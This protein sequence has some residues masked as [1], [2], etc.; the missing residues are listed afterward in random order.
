MTV[1]SSPSSRRTSLQAPKSAEKVTLKRRSFL[2][3]CLSGSAALFSLVYGPGLT[4]APTT[5]PKIGVSEGQVSAK[6]LGTAQDGGVPQIGC[7]C[8]NCKRARRDPTHNRLIVSLALLDTTENQAF[9]VDASPDIRPQLDM[10]TTKL[11]PRTSGNKNPLNGIILTHAHV[12]HYT[13]LMFFGYEAL[14]SQDLPVY[15][16]EKMGS[17]LSNNG[18]WSQLVHLKN[19]NLKVFSAA[20]NIP[21]SPHLAFQ[22]LWVPHRDEYSDTIGLK[23][24]GP[25]KKLLYIPDI[26]NWET[27]KID[28]LKEVQSVDYAL[29]DGTFFSPKELPGRDLSKIGH[30]FMR[31]S[32][33]RLASV[34]RQG[35]TRI[36]FTHFN[37][38]N[39]V[40]NPEGK[41]AKEVQDRGFG[42][43][44]EGL[45]LGL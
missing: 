2:R 6:V 5:F 22:P 36:Y 44:S 28:I 29:L 10:I 34:V 17:F 14:S 37:H 41:A 20:K 15:C 13:G 31:D 7:D 43:A 21:L 26:Q 33:D 30:P 42:L 8:P 25:R 35:K 18:P 3:G 45:E 39:P 12:G 32:M 11:D 9:L 38:S 27:W 23:I 19:I 1:P 16:S 24:V 4:A 40:L